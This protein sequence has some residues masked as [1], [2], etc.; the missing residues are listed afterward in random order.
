MY[1]GAC[2]VL[3]FGIF[4]ALAQNAHGL[5]CW[6]CSSAYDVTCRDYFN[7]T[8]IEINR[9]YFDTANYGNRQ[10]HPVRTDPHVE[11][12][13]DMHTSSYNQKNVCLKTVYKGAHGIPEVTRGC[14]M[15]QKTLKSGEC[16]EELKDKNKEFEF[17][18]T[19]ESDQC[20]AAGMIKTN[21][22]LAATV[23][24]VLAVFVR[25]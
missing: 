5:Q 2:L 7:I 10:V 1:R 12:C 3:A 25:K 16:P 17:C 23:P 20:N 14:R 11:I 24:V 21:L 19:C 8:R 4:F 22:F 18:G 6:K 15:V 13:D 9:R